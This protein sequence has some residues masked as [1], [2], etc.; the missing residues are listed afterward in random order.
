MESIQE[1]TLQ[2]SN[3]SPEFGQVIGG[4][5]NFTARSGTNQFH[6]SAYDYSTNED[7]GRG[8]TVHQ[9]WQWSSTAATKSAERF[10]RF[11]WWTGMDS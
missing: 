2:T 1:F 7:L 11:H 5:F 8:T 4:L 6:G 3:F 10:R 9:Q